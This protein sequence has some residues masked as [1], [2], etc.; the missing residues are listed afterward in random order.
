MAVW[1]CMQYVINETSLEVAK[2]QGAV[3]N[4]S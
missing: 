2:N 4:R 1:M 3:S